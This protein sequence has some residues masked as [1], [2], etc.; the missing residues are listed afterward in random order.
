MPFRFRFVTLIFFFNYPVS[1]ESFTYLPTLSLHDAFPVCAS[2]RAA[3][4]Y[5]GG[6]Y[7]VAGDRGGA[8]RSFRPGFDRRRRDRAARRST[9]PG[10]GRRQRRAARKREI[11]RASSRERVCLYV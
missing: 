8:V 6:R 7:L 5:R 2:V 9:H 1:T 4:L 10:R 11:G 3:S